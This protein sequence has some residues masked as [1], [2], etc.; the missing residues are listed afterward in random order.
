MDSEFLTAEE[1]AEY[2]R[3]PLSTVYKLVQDKR[4][5]GFKVGKHWRFRKDS[6]EK[7]I[8]DQERKNDLTEEVKFGKEKL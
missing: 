8:K 4:L 6:I 7:W 1:V 2:L 5:P 3:L